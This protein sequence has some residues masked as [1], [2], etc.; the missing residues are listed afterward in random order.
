MNIGSSWAEI[1]ESAVHSCWK[2]LC[3]VLVQYF[4]GFEEKLEDAITEVAIS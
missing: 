2:T 3:P 4:K 1:K